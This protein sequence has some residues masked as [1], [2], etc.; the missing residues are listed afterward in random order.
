MTIC[1]AMSLNQALQPY[2]TV[3]ITGASSGIGQCFLTTLDKM[4]SP[5]SFGNLSRR[6]PAKKVDRPLRHFSCD[7]EK[8]AEIDA[9]LPQ[10]RDWLQKETTGKILLIN[11][12][13]FGEYGRFQ[14]GTPAHQLG[15]IDVNVRAVVHLTQA[16]LPLLLE[17]GG[18]VMNIA[19][20][21]AW[22]PTPFLATYGATKAFLLH[23]SLACG[24]DLRG[25]G[26]HFLAVCP[27]PTT[28]E[29][30]QRAGLANAPDSGIGMT[31]DE[32]VLSSLDALVNQRTVVV[33]GIHNRLLVLL[34]RLLLPS[35]QARVARP[36]LARFRDPQKASPT[37]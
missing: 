35:M 30:G 1:G 24:R 26:V 7:L 15:M 36:I 17:R 23:W 16:L 10:V 22:Q 8:A 25:T 20:V 31:A 18:A 12:S 6:I 11:N 13:G 33:N 28:S 19:S 21:A 14:H 34:A 3:L 9:I 2:Q 32:V 27:G 5:R 37:R 29:F 4:V